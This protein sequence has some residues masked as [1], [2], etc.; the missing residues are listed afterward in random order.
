MQIILNLTLPFF[1]V[2]GLGYLAVKL[3]MLADDAVRSINVFVF[4]FAMP[5]LVIGALARQDF[6]TL[7]D[8]PFLIGWLIAGLAL[9]VI[10]GVLCW[11][12]FKGDIREIA[13]TGQAASVANV[14]FLGFPLLAAAFN[15]GAIGIAATAL[16]V[17]LMVLIP[18][19]ITMIEAHGGGSTAKIVRRVVKGAVFNPFLLAILTGFLISASNL[20]M[21]APAERLLQF[22]AS[23]AGP[24]ALFALGIS[25][26]A[27]RVEGD[28]AAISTIVILKL[29]GHPLAAY[30]AL[31]AL[32]VSEDTIL[33]AMV[34]A[35]LPVA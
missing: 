5:A 12:F 10:G 25:L 27:R 13:L 6:D 22:L 21:P 26:A 3:G 29:V 24:T 33:I 9:Y 30:A 34:I 14:G 17:D 1:A 28:T 32:G 31:S 19:S 4:N 8:V 16:L 2:V 15:K 11:L 23:A 20:D 7:V 35:A 18:L